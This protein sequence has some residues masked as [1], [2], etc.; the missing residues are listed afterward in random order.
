MG[1]ARTKN[2]RPADIGS[3]QKE[4]AGRV[5]AQGNISFRGGHLLF[6]QRFSRHPKIGLTC[7]LINNF[8]NRPFTPFD[9]VADQ[10]Q[11]DER[12][13]RFLLRVEEEQPLP[14]VERDG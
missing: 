3:P 13:D 8:E 9:M 1:S 7:S 11:N 14:D 10:N 4:P 6:G 2:C 12:L 5:D